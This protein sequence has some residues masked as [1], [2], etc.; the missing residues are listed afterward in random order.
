MVALLCKQTLQAFPPA[1][2]H[3]HWTEKGLNPS[4]SIM[5]GLMTQMDADAQDDGHTMSNMIA[6]T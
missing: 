5:S 3:K 2:G 6:T 1:V 4:W